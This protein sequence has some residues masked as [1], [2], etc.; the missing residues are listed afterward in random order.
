[1]CA[2]VTFNLVYIFDWSASAVADLTISFFF[3]TTGPVRLAVRSSAS[4]T[5]I[6]V[7]R[8]ETTSTGPLDYRRLQLTPSI[9]IRACV[10][11][12]GHVRLLGL[13]GIRAD[14]SYRCVG[15]RVLCVVCVLGHL[16]GCI[17]HACRMT[18]A[19]MPA[20]PV[21][22]RWVLYYY[23]YLCPNHILT[24]PRRPWPERKKGV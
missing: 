6:R 19:A 12:L 15:S 3:S 18:C 23:L 14:H 4:D 5:T 17:L 7:W 13:S 21:A 24:Y 20:L 9:S 8:R 11:S 10:G 22:I 2:L 1:M 16:V